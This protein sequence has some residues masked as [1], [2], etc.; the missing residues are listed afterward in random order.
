MY[1]QLTCIL[2][3]RKEKVETRG[4]K[5]LKRPEGTATLSGHG[6]L[7]LPAAPFPREA[8]QMDPKKPRKPLKYHLSPIS[9]PQSLSLSPSWSWP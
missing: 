5:E 3:M 9:K 1:R 7:C 6:L 8:P 2:E 4:E